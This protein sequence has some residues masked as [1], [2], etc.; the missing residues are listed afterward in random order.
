[1][2]ELAATERSFAQKALDYLML[3]TPGTALTGAYRM[4]TGD[5]RDQ[6]ARSAGENIHQI[7]LNVDGTKL[8]EVNNRTMGTHTT[9]VETR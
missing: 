7:V 6:A 5:A 4:A 8:A 3:M 2:A 1:M 9:A